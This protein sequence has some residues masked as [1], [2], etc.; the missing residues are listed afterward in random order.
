MTAKPLS[1]KQQIIAIVLLNIGIDQFSKY[2]VRLTLVKN[3]VTGVLF[4]FILFKNVDNS[5]AAL[6]IGSDLP[7]MLKTMYFQLLP[8]VFL[9]YLLRLILKSPEFSKL[10]VTGIAFALG[11]GFGNVIDRIVDGYVTDFIILNVGFFKNGV[12][13]IADV[14]IVVGIILVFT[15]I[16][17]NRKK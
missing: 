2:L 15:D 11:G 1:R 9:I 4:D 8:V 10:L 7:S 14:S 13:N 5:G 3:E 6:G 12:F 16:F 17:M